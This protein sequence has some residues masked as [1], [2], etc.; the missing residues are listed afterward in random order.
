[1]DTI[2][3][4]WQDELTRLIA[5]A[6]L[7]QAVRYA[8]RIA[9]FFGSYNN[10]KGQ[11]SRVELEFI[12]ASLAAIEEASDKPEEPVIVLVITAMSTDSRT[13]VFTFEPGRNEWQAHIG[14]QFFRGQLELLR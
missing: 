9:H 4:S 3:D 10:S 5:L 1:M 12:V 14:Y 2:P 13:M 8:G 11:I 6:G 7:P